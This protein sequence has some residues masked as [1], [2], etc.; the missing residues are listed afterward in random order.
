MK[1]RLIALGIDESKPLLY[2]WEIHDVRTGELK[3]RYIG[4]AVRG[5]GRPL[6]QYRRNVLNLLAGLPYRRNKPDG[7]RRV[8]RALADA[9][10]KG[11]RITL[12]LLR[13]VPLGEDI[14]EAERQAI[15]RFNCTLNG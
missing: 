4:K 8:H 9:V 6:S 3:G 12:T 1:F 11:D 5:S 13:N 15:R 7:F 14:N 10:I 2:Q